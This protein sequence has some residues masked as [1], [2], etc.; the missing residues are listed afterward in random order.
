LGVK[1]LFGFAP[2]PDHLGR[3]GHFCCPAPQLIYMR[4][5]QIDGFKAVGIRVE[6]SWNELFREMPEAWFKLFHYL[7]QIEHHELPCVDISFDVHDNIYTQFVSVPITEEGSY[8]EF[9]ELITV[10][11]MTVLHHVHKGDL[12]EIPNAFSEMYEYAD[13]RSWE[14]DEFKLDFG[15]TPDGSE[16]EHDLYIRLIQPNSNK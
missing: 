10:P 3:C 7:P 2:Y 6:A 4:R 12:T 13:N 1:S 11:S 5:I 9:M 8:P 14:T 15:Y 16:T